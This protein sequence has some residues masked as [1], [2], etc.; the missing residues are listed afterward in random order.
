[1][2]KRQLLVL[3]IGGV[4]LVK[5]TFQTNQ[6]P[7]ALG[8]KIGLKMWHVYLA[9]PISGFFLVL[10]SIEFF[11]ER[12]IALVKHQQVQTQHDFE[13]TAAMD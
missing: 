1:M 4:N 8:T 10:Y 6:I 5:I 12:I 13:S 7:P 2:Y 3:V 9:L 11:I